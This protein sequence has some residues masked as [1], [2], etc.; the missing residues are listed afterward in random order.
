METKTKKPVK[1]PDKPEPLRG[2]E[3]LRAVVNQ[4]LAHPE[5]W[6]QS[7]YHSECGTTHCVAGWAQVLGGLPATGAAYF[8]AKRLLGLTKTEADQ[9]FDPKTKLREIYDFAFMKLRSPK[10]MVPL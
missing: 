4:I 2:N 9:L 1:L 6:D 10:E 5:T 8:D 3:L 7:D